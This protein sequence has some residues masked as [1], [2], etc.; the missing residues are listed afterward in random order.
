MSNSSKSASANSS[1]VSNLFVNP[2]SVSV[3]DKVLYSYRY[4]WRLKDSDVVNFKIVTDLPE[5]HDLFISK[6]K[7]I[8]GLESFGREYLCSYSTSQLCFFEPLFS[9]ESDE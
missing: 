1:N 4:M 5:G 8:S 3:S 9:S 2:D 7:E 6:I